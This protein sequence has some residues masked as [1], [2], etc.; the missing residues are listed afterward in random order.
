[1]LLWRVVRSVLDHDTAVGLPGPG[2]F[3][4]KVRHVSTGSAV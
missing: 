4:V 3:R 1:M 2:S